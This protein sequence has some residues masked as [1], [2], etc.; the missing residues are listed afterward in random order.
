MGTC[1]VKHFNYYF[2]LFKVMDYRILKLQHL[3]P[4]GHMTGNCT[5]RLS[6]GKI[7]LKLQ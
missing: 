4:L 3:T 6:H 2:K 1:T 5:T 7:L